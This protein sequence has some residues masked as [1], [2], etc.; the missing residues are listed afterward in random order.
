MPDWSYRTVFQPLL[1]R[2][3]FE[4]A[5]DLAFGAMGR[6]TRPGSER[7]KKISPRRLSIEIN[8]TLSGVVATAAS[9]AVGAASREAS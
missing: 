7:G 2:L 5:R 4:T 3:S 1:F 6:L 8:I 9:V